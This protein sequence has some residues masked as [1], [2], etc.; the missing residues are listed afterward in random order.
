VKEDMR[1]VE[2]AKIFHI[3]DQFYETSGSMVSVAV[4]C[5]TVMTY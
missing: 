5:G 1:A 3:G 4:L 2:R